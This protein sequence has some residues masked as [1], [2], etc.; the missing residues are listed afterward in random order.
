MKN[1]LNIPSILLFTL[2]KVIGQGSNVRFEIPESIHSTAFK[3]EVL[4]S[5]DDCSVI[6][7][8]PL[9]YNQTLTPR[10]D[11]SLGVQYL[12][13]GKDCDQLF[14]ETFSTFK[15]REHEAFAP[16]PDKTLVLDSFEYINIIITDEFV[17]EGCTKVFVTSFFNDHNTPMS[18]GDDLY[19]GSDMI[20]ES[21]DPA[22]LSAPIDIS[23]LKRSF[24]DE[25]AVFDDIPGLLTYM[26]DH[27]YYKLK[28]MQV[29]KNHIV[30][31]LRA[32]GKWKAITP[33][34]KMEKLKVTRCRME[35]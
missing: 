25:S 6:S 24:E 11:K 31:Q 19:L 12:V 28:E 16:I 21:A 33:E 17:G 4:K 35:N 20:I 26:H 18:P 1:L 14:V 30:E 22:Q 13:S 23:G 10:D 9:E 27:S 2:G 5:G 34:H 32:D 3:I 8:V 29:N 7:Y 15:G